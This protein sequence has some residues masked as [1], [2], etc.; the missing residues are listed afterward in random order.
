M[1]KKE[2]TGV[3]HYPIYSN[4]TNAQAE[5]S[6]SSLIEL[7]IDAA[8]RHAEQWGFG[9]R[10]LIKNNHAWV[11]ARLAFDM[12]RYPRIE[13]TLTI[14]TWVESFNRHFTTR[15]FR[16]LDQKL[17]VIGYA[18]SVWSVIDFKTRDSVDITQYEEIGKLL[19]VLP[20][21]I[22]KPGRL[23]TVTQ[24]EGLT[25]RVKVSDLDINRHM[26]SSRY[27]DHLLDLFPLEDFD[28]SRIGRF[29]VQ[30]MNEALYNENI[31]LKKEKQEDGSYLLE[32]NNSQGTALCKC[33]CIFI[34]SLNI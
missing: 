26:T 1:L 28:N 7:L 11:L 24:D 29:E 9:F 12:S 31:L 27:V 19:Q 15:N 4:Q 34:N 10:D 5:I 8:S 23:G 13:E 6:V 16:L 30:Y 3:T 14:E 22:E 25:Y 21:P 33:K 32:M 2:F 20:C 17:N 18:R